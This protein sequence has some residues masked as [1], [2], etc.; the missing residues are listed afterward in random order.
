MVLLDAQY[1]LGHTISGAWYRLTSSSGAP[2]PCTRH[3]IARR[4]L[5]L[6]LKVFLNLG[7]L[8]WAKA[9]YCTFGTFLAGATLFVLP[10]PPGAFAPSQLLDALHKFPI[11][12]L[13]APPTAYRGLCAT[14]WKDYLAK[15]RPMSL[16]HCVSAGEPMNA[17]EPTSF[18]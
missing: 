10:P 11:T 15:N 3:P 1:T 13:C 14:E 7:D 9:A 4:R 2:V 18:F 5:T 16:E 17:G 12:T 8:G 6:P